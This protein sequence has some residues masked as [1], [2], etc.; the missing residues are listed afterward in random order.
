[1]Q[2]IQAQAMTT[3]MLAAFIK[4]YLVA[5]IEDFTCPIS[6]QLIRVPLS[7]SVNGVQQIFDS[8]FLQ[9]WR[10]ISNTCPN[11]RVNLDGIQITHNHLLQNQINALRSFLEE[12]DSPFS[13]EKIESE[14]K[15]ET[16]PI[17]LWLKNELLNAMELN[18]A[19]RIALFVKQLPICKLLLTSNLRAILSENVEVEREFKQAPQSGIDDQLNPAEQKSG[20]AA[21]PTFTSFLQAREF[22]RTKNLTE[23]VLL[24]YLSNHERTFNG[25]WLFLIRLMQSLD[26]SFAS[27]N[28]SMLSF[29]QIAENHE[30]LISEMTRIASDQEAFPDCKP[31]IND[32]NELIRYALQIQNRETNIRVPLPLQHMLLGGNRSVRHPAPA[33]NT[34]PSLSFSSCDEMD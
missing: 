24:A 17:F 33:N 26:I 22:L 3:T 30:M 20:H 1:M 16:A 4:D 32:L 23:P 8:S 29:S 15:K 14:L 13:Q 12:D 11:T 34:N 6:T 28:A 5:R 25:T 19:K 21:V 2:N 9:T 18:D 10:Q 7:Y 31:T 27:A